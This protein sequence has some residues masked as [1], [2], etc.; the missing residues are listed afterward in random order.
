MFVLV[1]IICRCKRW[2]ILSINWLNIARTNIEPKNSVQLIENGITHYYIAYCVFSLHLFHQSSFFLFFFNFFAFCAFLTLIDSK[3]AVFQLKNRL[4][5]KKK[6]WYRYLSF[7]QIY[8]RCLSL[9]SV[10]ISC[11]NIGLV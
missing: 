5:Q 10:L 2:K 9:W 3:Y 7:Q 6:D 8:N 4:L 1:L 11:E